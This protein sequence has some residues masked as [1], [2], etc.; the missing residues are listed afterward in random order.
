MQRSCFVSNRNGYAG[1][2]P[3]VARSS[4]SEL[5]RSRVHARGGV[6]CSS[7][8]NGNAALRTLSRRHQP[9]RARQRHL[10]KLVNVLTMIKATSE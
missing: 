1:D 7:R 5:K 2:T 3:K 9:R 6:A 8:Y 4:V 10:G